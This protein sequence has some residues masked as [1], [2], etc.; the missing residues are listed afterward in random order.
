MDNK[1]VEVQSHRKLCRGV[2][3]VARDFWLRNLEGFWV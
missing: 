1:K 3:G 2:D